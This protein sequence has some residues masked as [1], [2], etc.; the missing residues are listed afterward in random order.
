[1]AI[2]L[3]ITGASGAAYGLRLL[4]QLLFAKQ[5]VFLLI[6]E[7]AKVVIAMETDLQLP[8]DVKMIQTY[9]SKHYQASCGQLRVFGQTEWTAP[10]ASGSAVSQA[11]VIC[12][13]SS[14]TL[15]AIAHGLSRGLI[16][17]AADV[18]LKE[19]AK[20]ILVHR[21]TPL[22]VIHL[23]NMLRLAKI[24]ALI[25]PASP[26]FYNNPHSIEDIIDFIVARVLNHLNISHNLLPTWGG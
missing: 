14:A 8:T 15:A 2:T 24:G 6:S 18:M 10:I 1:M 25:L 7:P 5:E 4:E 12:P 17:R 16:E 9:L 19:Q 26:G 21:E 23:E 13:C 22:S 3:A 11:M 20:L